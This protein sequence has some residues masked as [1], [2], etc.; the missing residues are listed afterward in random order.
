MTIRSW[1]IITIISLLIGASLLFSFSTINESEL[2]QKL[3]ELIPFTVF[4]AVKLY[5]LLSIATALGLPRQIAA[6][7]AGFSFNLIFGFVIALAATVTGCIIT[8]FVAKFGLHNVIAQKHPKQLTKVQLFFEKD[9][10]TKAII[11]RLIPAGSN[12][13]TNL[14]AGSANLPARPYFLGS[15]LGYIPQMLVFT[16]AGYGIKLGT[17][18]HLIISAVLFVTALML[19]IRL[20]RRYKLPTKKGLN[21]P[22][23]LLK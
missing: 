20:Y 3:T 18:S 12:F 4:G 7:C 8:Y 11:I 16:L 23:K 6:F 13:L 22:F 10:F 21:S 19:G 17:T 9:L 5:L 2:Q 1:L 15:M 14:L